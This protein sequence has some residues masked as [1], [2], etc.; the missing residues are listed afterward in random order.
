MRIYGT[1]TGQLGKGKRKEKNDKNYP[2]QWSNRRAALGTLSGIDPRPFL[3]ISE[4]S[5][6]M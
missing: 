6:K 2:L 5:A 3:E 4:I 1:A